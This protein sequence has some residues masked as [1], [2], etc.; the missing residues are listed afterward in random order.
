MVLVSS[1]ARVETL[2][3]DSLESA[4]AFL[5]AC[6]LSQETICIRAINGHTLKTV[7]CD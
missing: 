2:R 4:V 6:K 3:F 1:S 5:A 7:Q